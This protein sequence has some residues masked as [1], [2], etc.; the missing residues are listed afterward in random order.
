MANSKEKTNDQKQGGGKG[1]GNPI[2]F[3]KHL[4]KDPITT[5]AEAEARKKEVMPWL[6]GS[7][8][9]AVVPGI[10]AGVVSALSFLTIFCMIGVV[11]L[12]FFG[13]LL[14]IISKAKAK[15]KALTCGK[16]NTMAEI[17]TPEEFAEF[18][19]YSVV[20][21]RAVFKGVSHPA[22]NNGVVS[23]IKATGEASA[24][25]TINLKCPHCGNVK[26]LEYHIAPFRCSATQTKVAALNV[27]MVKSVVENAVRAAVADYND[28]EKR[29]M[30]PYSIHSKKNPEYV[31]RAK[32][33]R[34]NDTVA[35]PNYN[36]AKIDYHKDPEEMVETFFLENQ[37]DGEIVDLS[38]P[39]KK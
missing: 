10:L 1:M 21:N 34:G 4:W 14:F 13:F 28:P 8:G 20:K 24:V 19:S 29:K 33:H 3:L 15:F 36:G 12:F 23:E 9:L 30:I 18:V 39:K 35:F 7:I 17:K 25:V 2:A 38:A 5:I 32:V 27:E 16:C 11:G 31:N 37:L 6:Y 22:S 26:Q